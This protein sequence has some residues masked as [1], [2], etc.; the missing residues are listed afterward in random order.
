MKWSTI[1]T[2]MAESMFSDVIQAKVQQAV[3]PVSLGMDARDAGFRRLTDQ[4]APRDLSLPAHER[5]Q[6]VAYY[7]WLTNPMAQWWVE[8]QVAYLTGEGVTIQSP[9]ERT[10]DILNA[11][12]TDGINQWALNLEKKVRELSMYGEQ[13]WPAFVAEGTGRVRLGYLDP[14]QIDAVIL[15]PDNAQV[16]IGIVTRKNE[17]LHIPARKF[18]T[19][20]GVGEEELTPLAQRLREDMQD[21]ETFFH[22][23]NNVSNASRGISDLYCKAD[24]LDGYD[25]FMFQR[26]E[27][28]DLANRII[29]DLELAG[30]S[31]QQIEEFKKT[32]KLPP[33][34]GVHI[35]NEKVKLT[36]VSPNMNA[37]DAEVDARL[38]KHQ[39]LAP[40]PEHWF[41][42]GG[43]ANLAT[44]K[45]MDEPTFKILVK[46][47]Q[48]WKSILEGNARFTIRMAKAAGRLEQGADETVTAVFPE[49]V[50]ADL[51]KLGSTLQQ[52]S[53]SASTMIINGLITKAEGRK[54][55]AIVIKNFG[56][57]LEELKEDV[58]DKLLSRDNFDDAA[59]DIIGQAKKKMR[60]V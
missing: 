42:G 39:A 46:R 7:L 4:Q 33:P 23:I 44:A 52:V 8:T 1:K 14:C 41:G 31:E 40:Y 18:K 17:H 60:A 58:L 25:Q 43:D 27:R 6:E 2:R 16:A 59:Q 26:L 29:H 9:D 47:Q 34:G 28:A 3:G 13:F 15:D 35:H 22:A 53:T 30:F 20:L 49:M 10:Q 51:T 55:V 24:W 37:M 11:W 56:L 54:L 36:I 48:L 32:Y 5:M 50:T 21:G 57:E 38:F 19:I 45:E 12:W